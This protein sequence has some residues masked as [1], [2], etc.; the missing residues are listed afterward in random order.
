MIVKG[1]FTL[2]WGD[3]TI[4]D[5]ETID[6]SYD[7]DTDD[8]NTLQGKVYE[9]DGA[10]KVSATITL[11]ASDIPALAAL[12]PQNFVENGGVLSTG[13]TVNNANGA[14]DFAPGNCDE[15]LVKNPFDIISCNNPSQVYRI[16]DA[17]T[18]FDGLSVD[19]KVAKAMVR[20]I[21]E[22]AADEAGLQIFAENTVSV[23]S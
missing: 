1:P 9:L 10:V 2:K 3:N 14:M 20:I 18:R 15:A 22:S 13:E 12:L 17:R 23:V 21:G 16:V 4:E 19:D 6:F 11:L 7:T 5:V 8:T